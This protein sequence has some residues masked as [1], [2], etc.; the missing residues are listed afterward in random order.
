MFRCRAYA[1]LKMGNA[2]RAIDDF[3]SA[4]ALHPTFKQTYIARG[5]AF[6]LVG[7]L[8]NAQRDYER[9]KEV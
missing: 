1:Y 6:E 9:A 4:I 3:T 8:E 7:D 5:K 2:E